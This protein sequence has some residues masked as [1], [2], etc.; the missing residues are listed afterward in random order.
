MSAAALVALA[1]FAAPCALVLTRQAPAGECEVPSAAVAVAQ[2]EVTPLN[3]SSHVPVNIRIAFAPTAGPTRPLAPI[4]LYPADRAGSF[5]VPLPRKSGRL[6]FTLI[7][8]PRPL[9]VRIGPISW[10]TSA[11]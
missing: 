3:N 2:V 1:A 7:P 6:V 5:L 9:S 8:D 11:P 10:R 4:S